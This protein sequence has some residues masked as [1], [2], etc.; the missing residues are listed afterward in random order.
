M[1]RQLAINAR[2]A[3]AA[4]TASASQQSQATIDHCTSLGKNSIQLLLSAFGVY[5]YKSFCALS[6]EDR[7]NLFLSLA[8]H[9]GGMR[10]GHFPGR[11]Y[12]VDAFL[13]DADMSFRL[14]TD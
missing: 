4:P 5:D 6:R 1:K 12:T 2:A 9:T 3:A 13:R 11:Q 8:Q 10:F 14:I 7:H